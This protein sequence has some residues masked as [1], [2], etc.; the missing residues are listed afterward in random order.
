MQHSIPEQH[1][2][3]ILGPVSISA[4]F[5]YYVLM[6]CSVLASAP[7]LVKQVTLAGDATQAES[8]LF[9]G[10][11]PW[12]PNVVLHKLCLFSAE[13]TTGSL[14]L[15]ATTLDEPS[16]KQ[17]RLGASG[18]LNIGTTV[19]MQSLS[20]YQDHVTPLLILALH[21]A[22]F[23]C[24]LSIMFMFEF[25]IHTNCNQ[26]FILDTANQ[27]ISLLLRTTVDWALLWPVFT[28]THHFLSDHLMTFG[29]IS[30][31]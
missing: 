18:S 10:T 15:K 17:L 24:I 3:E 21:Y 26:S 19:T 16:K 9:Y 30:F 8:G 14:C 5:L 1:T 12:F 28:Q 25:Q 4:V 29:C 20:C 27:L 23:C 6:D 2:N 22:H 31:M 13:G 11:V 7:R